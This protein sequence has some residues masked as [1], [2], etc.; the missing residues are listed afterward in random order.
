MKTKR[1]TRTLAM[2]SAFSLAATPAF[3]LV[4]C[5]E[6]PAEEVGESIDDAADDAG[7]AID[8]AADDVDD[9]VDD[10]DD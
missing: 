5:D 9:A 7:D 1:T 8:D 10:I 6:G 4:G 2:L 3:V